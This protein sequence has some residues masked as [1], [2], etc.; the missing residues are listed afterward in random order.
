MSSVQ[1]L[2]GRPRAWLKIFANLGSG[3]EVAVIAGL[4]G[5]SLTFREAARRSRPACVTAATGAAEL[6]LSA[7]EPWLREHLRFP[8][9]SIAK[10]VIWGRRGCTDPKCRLSQSAHLR[11]VY[12]TSGLLCLWRSNGAHALGRAVQAVQERVPASGRPGQRL[13]A[14]T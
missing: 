13:P 4:R 3:K 14:K 2:P 9:A 6:G 1:K 7:A 10:K 8:T 11:L 12:G 5:P